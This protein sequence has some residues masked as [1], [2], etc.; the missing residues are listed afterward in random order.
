VGIVETDPAPDGSPGVREHFLCVIVGFPVFSRWNLSDFDPEKKPFLT[1]WRR[2]TV[3][4][5]S[6]G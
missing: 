5:Q 6:K 3:V 2:T 1:Q 4:L